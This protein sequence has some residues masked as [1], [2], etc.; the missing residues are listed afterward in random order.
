MSR[1]LNLVAI[2]ALLC[3][4][5]SAED[6]H[7]MTKA[8][9][10]LNDE[11]SLIQVKQNLAQP[12]PISAMVTGLVTQLG[13]RNT[14]VNAAHT[15][16]VAAY[17]TWSDALQT[18]PAQ[19]DADYLTASLTLQTNRQALRDATATLR[20]EQKALAKVYKQL[21][22]DGSIKTSL[23]YS[24]TLKTAQDAVATAQAATGLFGGARAACNAFPLSPATATAACAPCS[25]CNIHAADLCV[26]TGGADTNAGCDSTASA[27]V[28]A[29]CNTCG[30][31][32]GC[33]TAALA[34]TAY[35]TAR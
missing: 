11:T 19:A 18:M 15:A 2:V 9:C 32:S 10:A 14:A 7:D 31:T 27:D 28:Q 34:C 4:S 23:T 29:A 17:K 5:A 13:V 3:T 21:K 35:W 26:P 30:T 33:R 6:C 22:K 24:D 16:V 1:Y 20:A 12:A 25:A 8:A